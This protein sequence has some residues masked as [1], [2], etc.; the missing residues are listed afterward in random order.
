MAKNK[1][2]KLYRKVKKNN[3]WGSI[4]A[5]TIFTV[6]FVAM[7]V[8]L[9]GFFLQYILESKFVNGY[10]EVV[11]LS[12]IYERGIEN[13]DIKSIL[14]ESDMDFVVTDDS[15]N[16]IYKKGEDTRSTKEA[17]VILSE[18]NVKYHV[19][20]DA[21][22]D[23]IYIDNNN[24]LKLRA[25]KVFKWIG[26]N[27][28]SD[29]NGDTGFVIS[30]TD[31][32]ELKDEL[33]DELGEESD[34]TGSSTV[35]YSNGVYFQYSNNA[36]TK[37]KIDSMG[38]PAWISVD[39]KDG[40]HFIGKAVFNLN[41][42]DVILFLEIYAAV[43]I[44]VAIIVT[45][46][47]VNVI[48]SIVHQTRLTS[49]FFLD[50]TTQG[51]NWMWYLIN[52]EKTL[53]KR[54]N[55]KENYAVA[56][57][58]FKNY[59]NYA[60]CH[61]V[62][63]G[64]E[65][66]TKIYMTIQREIQSKEKMAHATTSNFALLLKYEDEDKLKMR[67]HEL[68][69]KLEALGG[70]HDFKFQIG[71]DLIPSTK[72]E[73]GKTASRKDISIE[74]HYNNACSARA[75]LSGSDES[76]IKIF[77]NKLLEDQKWLDTVQEHQWSAIKNEEFKVYYQPKYN[78]RTDELS[79]A[80]ALIRWESPEYGFVTPGRIIPL[81]EKNGF[82]TEID[83]Y[84]ISH[85]ARDQKA[86]LDQ[87]YKCVPVS[88]NVSRA[89]FAEKDLAEQIRDMVDAAGCP[90]NLIEIELTES[91]FFDDK[92]AMIET[93]KKLKNYGFVVSMDDFGSGYSSLNS[94][95]DMPLDIL[96]LDAEF[97][98]GENAG[99]RG[100]VVVSEAIKLAKSLNM[101]TVA[102]GVEEKGQVD[103]LAEQGCDMIQGYYYAKPMPKDDYT[104]RMTK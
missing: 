27:Y 52:G 8:F 35:H 83:H 95:K 31:E 80:E 51:R 41:M 53:R 60:L 25:N 85:V 84:M 44:L 50:A 99:E 66:L 74:Q 70:A 14:E 89:H 43:I 4:I 23:M 30:T 82:I 32:D 54:R 67:L 3:I 26:E 56:N 21:E 46:L 104:E 12:K 1:N 17:D 61:S 65:M 24:N 9:S 86:W 73:K 28:L 91:A 75:T 92:N 11:R 48:V 47:F 57:L 59:R 55:A 45:I 20:E 100:E 69:T 97:F 33:K 58:V 37:D 77:D 103:F 102:E 36:D 72:N 88:V 76:G 96:K 13:D 98:R 19:V 87:G 42:R 10:D 64:E 68:I 94:L 18:E 2:Q 40:E 34:G 39:T 79:G 38:I 22:S 16:V 7:M 63:D 93:I 6:L 5:F 15:G 78:P 81:F 29:E 90:H 62:K 49:L 101:R 71:V